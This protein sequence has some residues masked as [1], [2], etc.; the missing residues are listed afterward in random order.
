M[1]T[2]FNRVKMT[3]VATHFKVMWLQT[4]NSRKNTSFGEVMPRAHKI[5]VLYVSSFNPIQTGRGRGR[6]ILPARTLEAYNVFDKQAKATELG[7]FS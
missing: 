3:K 4:L 5:L 7:D 6:R 2:I 1:C